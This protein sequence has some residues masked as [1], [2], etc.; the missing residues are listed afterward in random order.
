LIHSDYSKRKLG[1]TLVVNGVPCH[2]CSVLIA[3][4]VSRLVYLKEGIY[5]YKDW[6]DDQAFLIKSNVQL[7][8]I[9]HEDL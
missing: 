5:Q 8:E 4:T 3:S 7:V 1:A 2:G 9:T 6:E